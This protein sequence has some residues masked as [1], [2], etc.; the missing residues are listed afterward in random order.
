MRAHLRSLL[1]RLKRETEMYLRYL[2]KKVPLKFSLGQTY[3]FE[4]LHY[5]FFMS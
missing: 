4:N 5:E 1:S 3:K 2:L